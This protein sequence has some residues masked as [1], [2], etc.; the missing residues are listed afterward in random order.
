MR[1]MKQS[2]LKVIVV[3]IMLGL[4]LD[5]CL[6]QTEKAVNS[7][8]TDFFNCN[9][10]SPHVADMFRYGEFGTSLFTGRMQQTIPI[11]TLD[12][13][14][15]KMNIALHYNAEG[16][17]PRKHSGYVGYNWFLEAGGCITREVQGYPDETRRSVS[18]LSSHYMEGMYHFLD[19][20]HDIDKNDVFDLAKTKDTSC[21]YENFKGHVI[22]DDCT[23]SV[24]Y[25]PDIFHFDFLG[26]KGTFMINN[27]GKVQIV[28][29]D[30]VEVKL[31][32]ILE[33]RDLWMDVRNQVPYPARENS[34][35]TVKTID[36]YTYVFG[37]DYS[38]LEWT[39]NTY[40]DSEGHHNF[41][42]PHNTHVNSPYV[43]TWHLAKIIAPNGRIATFNYMPFSNGFPDKDCPLWEF[44]EF[45]DRY[46]PYYRVQSSNF[47]SK[48]H[49]YSWTEISKEMNKELFGFLS[50]EEAEQ[51]RCAMKFDE[52]PYYPESNYVHSATKTCIL[53]SIEISGVQPL[54]I[55]FVNKEEDRFMYNDG[56][57]AE[58]RRKNYQLN[59]I[60]VLTQDKT[61]KTADLGYTYMSYNRKKN[62][63]T[64][65]WRFL[66][67]I[68]IS[69]VGTYEM[70]YYTGTFPD[71]EIESWSTNYRDP[72]VAENDEMD[73]YGYY[74][75]GDP[76]LALLSQITYPTGG[77]QTYYYEQYSFDKKRMYSV[78]DNLDLEMKTVNRG[79]TKRGARIY[80][81]NTYEKGGNPI[82]TKTYS[83]FDGVY[84][85]N[86]KV[87]NLARDRFPEDGWPV[88]FL[89]NYGL[90][91]THIGYSK[92]TEAIK[93]VQGIYKNIYQFDMGEDTYLSIND[94]NIN[95]WYECDNPKFGIM[96]GPMLYSSQCHK[97]G[98]LMSV[99]N[100]DSNGK[101]LKSTNYEYNDIPRKI[102]LNSYSYSTQMC[103]D[104]I[105][106]F[107]HYNYSE[108]SKKL[109]IYPDRLTKEETKEDGLTTTKT[110]SYDKK[111]RVTKE[112]VTD[113]RNIEHFTKYTYPDNICKAANS[114]MQPAL[115]IMVSNNRVNMPVESV[116]GYIEGNKNE[117]ITSGSVNLYAKGSESG[118]YIY[119]NK[120]LSLTMSEPITDYQPMRMGS[121]DVTYDPRYKLDAEY[122]F[123]Q[124]G[125][126]L[127]IK[128]FGQ[129]ETAY[130]WNGIYPTSKTIGNQTW[131]Y[132]FIPHVGVKEIVD[133]RGIITRYEYDNAGRLIKESQVIDGKEQVL[134][135]Y[136][137]HIKS[138]K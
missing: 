137:Y 104:T 67:H 115:R 95:A 86:F 134:N 41:F 65:N 38:K 33:N 60:R 70:K 4:G 7:P 135:V 1:F 29:G 22:G 9:T 87:Y 59:S 19:R 82:E 14:D 55:V 49:C 91:D 34:S 3:P 101:L 112:T 37:G 15:F 127:S 129:M 16:F 126:L 99:E 73:E 93:N 31:S 118:L 63:D 28:S 122:K 92:V 39:V 89:A 56:S 30:Y 131:K 98:K 32:G 124:Q 117:K 78:T 138:E 105:V 96:A 106:I 113:S 50:E 36:G 12:D 23:N 97:W 17:K 121:S 35:I 81:V 53:K 110:Y 120:T 71:L 54:K 42:W 2:L 48:Y 13:P 10:I 24:D 84:F 74:V 5:T 94:K 64:F 109:Y 76:K 58:V 116:S 72:A 83:Y 8:A 133:P 111:F 68:R 132:S 130:T 6:A 51:E 25:M 61:I 46:A 20:K 43:T 114:S 40:V 57:Y 75:G 119:L 136:Q 90:L 102:D 66:S 44:N 69:G 103:T 21:F 80:E 88:R 79:G 52:A 62:E 45:F 18:Y 108:I 123:N 47:L 100:Y 11:Y 107:S 85:D 27:A 125:R 77:Y 128:P 26:Y